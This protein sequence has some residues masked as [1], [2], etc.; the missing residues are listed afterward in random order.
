MYA[1]LLADVFNEKVRH[2]LA[3]ILSIEADCVASYPSLEAIK[4]YF[5]PK[6]HVQ[7]VLETNLKPTSPIAI[8]ML[9]VLRQQ[10]H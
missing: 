2:A 5:R 1:Y 6:R 3:N 8:A 4:I 9:N 7:T 10:L